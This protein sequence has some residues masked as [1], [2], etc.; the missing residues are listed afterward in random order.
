MPESMKKR[1]HA[2]SAGAAALALFLLT[3]PAVAAAQGGAVFVVR[4]AERADASP[5]SVLSAAGEARASRLGAILK[6]A[7]I[8]QIYTTNLRRTVQTAAP[9]AAALTVTPVELAVGDTDALVARVRAA[10]PAGRVLV[11]GHS[12]TVPEILMRL[13]VTTPITIAD[14]EYDNLF[15]A[16]PQEGSA[17]LLLELKY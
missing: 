2:S 6:N 8:T 17:T 3:V 14:T 15:I 12:N 13:G 5:D 11:V 10:P 7:G 9:L 1:P 4:H 16:I